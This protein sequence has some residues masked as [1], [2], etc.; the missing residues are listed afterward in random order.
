MLQYHCDLNATELIWNAVK[1][2]AVQ[3]NV[4]ETASEIKQNY[5]SGY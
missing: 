5:D 3:T 1:T 2:R 4:A